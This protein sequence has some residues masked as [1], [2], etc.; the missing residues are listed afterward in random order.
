MSM[1]TIDKE[2]LDRLSN[3]QLDVRELHS[4]HRNLSEKVDDVRDEIEKFNHTING[5]GTP[6]MKVEIDRLKQAEARRRWLN[7][8]VIG[9][10]LSIIVW[11]VTEA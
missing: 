4:D 6:G 3:I 11:L 8:A 1:A 9:T 2:I 10:V 7:R 5:N